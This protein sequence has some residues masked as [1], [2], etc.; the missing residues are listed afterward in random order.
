MSIAIEALVILLGIMASC[1]L[2]FLCYVVNNVKK[3]KHRVIKDYNEA[4]D[5]ALKRY[6]TYIGF[7][8]WWS[9]K[10]KIEIKSFFDDDYD[11]YN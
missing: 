4:I 10:G 5:A 8:H 3:V 7:Q 11:D 6:E 2:I 9:S 1:A